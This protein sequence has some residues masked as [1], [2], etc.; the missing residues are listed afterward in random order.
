MGWDGR[1]GEEQ[2]ELGRDRDRD[3][4][5]PQKP[6]A[7]RR[8]LD[9]SEGARGTREQKHKCDGVPRAWFV[10][11][12]LLSIGQWRPDVPS[13]RGLCRR[14]LSITR[15]SQTRKSPPDAS[16]L[17]CPFIHCS[18]RCGCGERHGRGVPLPPLCSS[19]VLP[20]R[21]VAG[22]P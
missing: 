2:D 3:R 15:T 8:R 21:P 17:K 13:P 12:V 22:G 14:T 20:W 5:S 1:G 6:R 4:D 7:S 19:N 10:R 11:P 16:S 18:C 9:A